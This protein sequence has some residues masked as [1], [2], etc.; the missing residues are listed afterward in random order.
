M[1]GGNQ[2]LTAIPGI[3]SPGAFSESSEKAAMTT[4]K[5]NWPRHI[6]IIMDGNGRW[7]QQHGLP[8]VLGHR[9]GTE[10]VREIVSQCVESKIE[11]LT[12]FAF[13][14]ENWRRPQPE[15]DAIMSLIDEFIVS[16]RDLLNKN[17]VRIQVIG[18]RSRLREQT[19][20]SIEETIAMLDGNRRLTLT[21]AL[22]YGG[23]ADI[24]NAA[25]SLALKVR[26]GLIDV[27]DFDERLFASE[28]SMAGL[29]DPDLLIRTS[30]EQRLSNFLLWQLAYAEMVF[31]PVLWPDFT[32][33]LFLDAVEEFSRR[34]RR[35]GSLGWTGQEPVP[36]P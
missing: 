25:K 10:A 33:N 8:R 35:Y 2:P 18:D 4:E 12:L 19:R 32:K 7:A 9:H 34:Q 13:S 31:V 3:G 28:L 30:G 6:A 21:L 15:I 22:S 20:K 23:R 36:L 14:S 29:P 26:Q 24:V 5:P 11:M 16:E 17:G 1:P 27:V